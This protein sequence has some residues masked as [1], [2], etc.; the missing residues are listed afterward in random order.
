MVIRSKKM[1]QVVALVFAVVGLVSV[2]E[3]VFHG[4][5]AGVFD[6]DGTFQAAGDWVPGLGCPTRR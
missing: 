5:I 1:L 2:A 3:A 6:P 4:V